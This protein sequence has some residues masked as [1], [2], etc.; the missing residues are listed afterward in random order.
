MSP[1]IHPALIIGLLCITA[2]GYAVAT[3]GMKAA[4]GGATSIA[5]FFI[6]AGFAIAVVAEVIVL[7]QGNMSLVY[8]GIIVAETVLVLGYASSIG[9]GLSAPQMAGAGLVLLGPG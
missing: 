8:M 2:A 6:L 9:N 1:S 3:I 4:S 5:A 7:R